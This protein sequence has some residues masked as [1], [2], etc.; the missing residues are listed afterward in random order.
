[1][2]DGDMGDGK[3]A[4]H[5]SSQPLISD[6]RLELFSPPCLP[7]AATWSARASL[8]ADIEA[9]LPYLN[10]QL[11]GAEY[12]PDAK[13]LVWKDR[14]H[15]YAFRSREI[16][17]GPAQ[18]REEAQKLVDRAVALA[19]KAWSERE[20]SEPLYEK[21]TAANLMQIYRLLPRT[22]CG[23]CGCGTCMAFA[24]GLREG[25]TELA[26]CPVLEQPAFE[27]NRGK[28]MEMLG[29]AGQ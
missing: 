18:D 21:R 13:V 29:S 26:C 23:E 5:G 24:A 20:H 16:K 4:R 3:G 12:E 22:N 6:Y 28:L 19:N 10:A 8:Y 14:G 25:D 7:G 11:E 2:G 1:M 27:E 15:K 9:V 17:A